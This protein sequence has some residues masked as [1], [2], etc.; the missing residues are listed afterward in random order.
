MLHTALIALHA[1]SGLVALVFGLVTTRSGRLFDVYLWSLVS[2]GIFLAATVA[3]EWS[4]LDTAARVLFGAF[5]V[6]AGFMIWLAVRARGMRP[7]PS[8]RYLD[9]VGFTVVGLF[10]AFVVIVV[11][12]VSAPIWLVVGSGVLIAIVGHLAIRRAKGRL[13]VPNIQMV[14]VS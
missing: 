4:G 13:D 1:L 11:L 5:V 2:M 6:L 8:A 3:V 7:R 10:D 12:D 9:H 14:R